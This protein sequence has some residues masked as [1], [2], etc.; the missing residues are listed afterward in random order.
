M[1]NYVLVMR[2]GAIALLVMVGLAAA[3][4]VLASTG[5]ASQVASP[6]ETVLGPHTTGRFEILAQAVGDPLGSSE[7]PGL[8]LPHPEPATAGEMGEGVVWLT[9]RA[10]GTSWA[11]RVD[12]SVVVDVSVDG[13]TS[14]Q[15]VLF[16]GANPFTYTGFTGPLAVGPHI[17][18]V[19]V[20][21]TLSHTAASPIVDVDAAELGV[22]LPSDPDYWTDAY[23]PVIYGRESSASKYTPLLVDASDAVEAGGDHSLQYVLAVSAHDQ[24]DSIVPA[25]QWALWGRM[26]DIVSIVDETVAPDGAVTQATYASCGCEQIPDFPDWV[27]AP[28][29]TTA[30]LAAPPPGQVREEVMDAHPWTY[31]ISNE[32]LPREHLISTNPDDLLVGDYRQYAIIDSNIVE[33]GAQDVQFEI[34]VAGNPT[35]YS[36]DYRQMTAGVPSTIPFND[37]GHTR[38]V[39]KLPLGWG[40]ITGLRIRLDASFGSLT[41][42]TAQI[43]SLE[44]QAHYRTPFPS[45][46]WR[47]WSQRTSHREPEG[48]TIRRTRQMCQVTGMA[49][50]RRRYSV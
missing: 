49:A 34:Q 38:T 11:S 16:D 17:L 44:V 37:G 21:P 5:R 1:P 13:G 43:I 15:I 47:R 31:Q 24:G 18:S 36:T 23:A 7:G 25:Y 3:P 8:V 22:V 48:S 39:V 32:E 19:A 4:P 30:P 10:P 46:R 45:T 2:R 33:Q 9:M 28:E 50:R 20:S 6:R 41:P 26:T 35:W 42:A 12:T 14:Q 40:R 29:E 27:M